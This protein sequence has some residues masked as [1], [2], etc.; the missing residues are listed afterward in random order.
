MV[1]STVVFFWLVAKLKVF[2]TTVDLKKNIK[3]GLFLFVIIFNLIIS[4]MAWVHFCSQT[5]IIFKSESIDL[6]T[7]HRFDI[8][9]F[10]HESFFRF[11]PEFCFFLK[12]KILE[13]LE[14]YILFDK[15]SM[16]KNFGSRITFVLVTLSAKDKKDEDKLEVDPPPPHTPPPP[17]LNPGQVTNESLHYI[18]IW[19]YGIFLKL[20]PCIVLTILTALLVKALV[21]V[22]QTSVFNV[23]MEWE[24][25]NAVYRK[26]VVLLREVYQQQNTHPQFGNILN[27]NFF[28][29]PP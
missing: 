18:N 10:L 15:E 2:P 17:P 25:L 23:I 5:A 6:S 16:T 8:F 12:L 7:F 29:I 1:E 22:S 28:G 27:F 24:I 20:I 14:M 9:R 13:F 4:R 3:A 26:D 11:I 19:F 21:E